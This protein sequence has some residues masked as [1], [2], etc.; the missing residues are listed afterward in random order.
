MTYSMHDDIFYANEEAVS[1]KRLQRQGVGALG[2][3]LPVQKVNKELLNLF[4]QP[5]SDYADLN[6][7][8]WIFFFIPYVK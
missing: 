6:F 1:L 3:F 4:T 5:L 8:T 2:H 7:L